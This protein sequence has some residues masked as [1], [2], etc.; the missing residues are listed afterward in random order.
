MIVHG[1]SNAAMAVLVRSHAQE[2]PVAVLGDTGFGDTD[3]RPTRIVISAIP[4]A[5]LQ[6]K[7]AVLW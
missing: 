6:S 2:P 5:M 4:D 3:V 7:N 1:M